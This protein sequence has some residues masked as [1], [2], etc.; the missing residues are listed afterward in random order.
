MSISNVVLRAMGALALAAAAVLPARAVITI[1]SHFDDNLEG[2]TVTGG[3]STPVWRSSAT[4]SDGGCAESSDAQDAVF[5]Y[6]SAPAKFLGDRGTAHGQS[7]TFRVWESAGT[8]S[9][10]TIPDVILTSP[11]NTIVCSLTTPVTPGGWNDASVLLVGTPV[12]NP[13]TVWRAGNANGPPATDAQVQ[14]VL[15][16]LTSLQI[17]GEYISGTDTGR[18]DS[19]TMNLADVPPA[20]AL[21]VISDFNAGTDDGWTVF[22]DVQG[23]S[24]KPAWLADAAE[25]AAHGHVEATDDV[26]GGV[27]YWSAPAKF[28]G[29]LSNAFGKGLSFELTQSALYSQFDAPDI[30][31]ES[32]ATRLVY[33]LRY[34]PNVTWT[35]YNVPLRDGANWHVGDLNGAAP[36]AAH[37]RDVMRLLTGLYI[38]GEFISGAD[39]DALD[40]VAMGV[41]PLLYGDMDGDTSNGLPDVA[42]CLRRISGLETTTY[43]DLMRGD[44]WPVADGDMGDG[45]LDMRDVVEVARRVS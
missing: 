4:G 36:D 41:D 45:V 31:L 7:L 37:F 3:G 39:T 23:G 13:T 24:S 21:P 19:V 1:Q 16:N 11:T 17:R 10:G 43:D 26:Q 40:N 30:I 28:L 32:G 38:R 42:W 15:A 6:W 2:W 14:D 27:W 34:H 22:G 8:L 29:N 12:S 44:L 18:L 35:P 9:A 25:G 20:A 33:R 5:W